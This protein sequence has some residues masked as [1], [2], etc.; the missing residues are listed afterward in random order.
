MQTP[1]SFLCVFCGSS[2]GLHSTFRQVAQELGEQMAKKKIGLV[3]GGAHVGL[4]GVVADA[5]L[6]QGGQ[7]IGVMPQALINLEV[8]HQ[9][10]SKFYVVQSMHERKQ[11]LYDLSHGFVALPGG[12]GTMDEWFEILTWAQL[13]HHHKPIYILNVEVDGT[14]YFSPMIAQLENMVKYG[15]M[16][17][18]HAKLFHV[19]NSVEQLLDSFH[20][21][22]R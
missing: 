21:A 15:F 1:S 6:A 13:R 11:K 12:P 7:A 17:A 10:L 18:E 22:C 14:G 4:M 5:V 19:V 8:A 20:Q 3:Y 16:R 9:N 2:A